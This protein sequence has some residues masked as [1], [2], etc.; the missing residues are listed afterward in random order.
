[1]GN[2]KYC[3]EDCTVILE[4]SNGKLY[5]ITGFTEDVP[6]IPKK[7]YTIEDDKVH[8]RMQNGDEIKITPVDIESFKEKYLVNLEDSVE[9]P[10]NIK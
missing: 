4:D 7:W 9:S 10:F 1:M 8:C 5:P 3:A 6:V 2:S